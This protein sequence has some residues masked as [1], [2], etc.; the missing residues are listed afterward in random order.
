MQRM[1]YR[2]RFLTPAF[3]G[4]AEQ[5]GQWRTPPFKALL[6][7]WWRVVRAER[8]GFRID[9]AAMRRDEGRLFGNAWLDGDF[10]KSAVRLRLSTWNDG[11][12]TGE[13]WW[14]DHA[15]H[16]SHANSRP[17]PRRTTARRETGEN[18]AIRHPE[19]GREGRSIDPLLYLGYGPLVFRQEGTVL[20]N[21]AAIQA[22]ETA[23]LSIAAPRAETDDLRAALA[24]MNAYGTVGGRSRNGW[25]SLAIE[26][27]DGTS[28]SDA[29]HTAPLADEGD[30]I[31]GC[32]RPWDDALKLDWPHAIGRDGAGPLV[33][34]TAESYADWKALMRD[35]AILKIGLRTMF[36]FPNSRPPHDR[37]QDRHWLSY[38]VTKHKHRI[39]ERK[40]L[41]LPNSLRFKVRPD[42]D[43]PK[44]LSG[45]IFHVPCLPPAEFGPDERAIKGVWTR[46]HRLLD[47]LTY[48]PAER[49][50]GMIDDGE[51]RRTLKRS[52]DSLTLARSPE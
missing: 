28:G 2:I 26:P 15:D 8:H 24:L 6:R 40:N 29:V 51:R 34:R 49:G 18:A 41:R 21:N 50:Y 7:Q 16:V 38:P 19:V 36:V 1:T 17:D 45:V 33:W 39:W 52:L 12:A 37:P 27:L 25:G 48:L 5:S 3:L 20:K 42:H 13:Q 43:D 46:S 30:I 11:R 35:L 14:F 47:E 10:R 32:I 9:V 22:G 31:R 23:E 44:R 4:N